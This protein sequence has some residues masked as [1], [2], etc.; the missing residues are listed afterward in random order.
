MRLEQERKERKKQRDREKKQRQKEAGT[1]LTPA[2]KQERARQQQMLL[3]MKAQGIVIPALEKKEGESRGKPVRYDTK[4]R[5]NKEKETKG[6]KELRL[7]RLVNKFA[8]WF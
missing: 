5:R 7:I 8:C 1:Y 6:G 3:A 2:Q 4:R